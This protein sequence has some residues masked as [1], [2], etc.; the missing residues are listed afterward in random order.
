MVTIEGNVPEKGRREGRRMNW[1][2]NIMAWTEKRPEDIHRNARN[3]DMPTV[4]A[5]CGR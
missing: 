3:R 5:D 2:D 4:R 1:K